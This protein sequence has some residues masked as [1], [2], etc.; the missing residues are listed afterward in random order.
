MLARLLPKQ[1][2]GF[3]RPIFLERRGRQA[4]PLLVGE[5][6]QDEWFDN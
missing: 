5:D 1:I 6:G 4:L 2:G 3:G